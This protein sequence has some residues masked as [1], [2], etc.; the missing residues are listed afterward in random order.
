MPLPQSMQ[1]F[2]DTTPAKKLA[3]PIPTGWYYVQIT[4][5]DLDTPL[6]GGGDE[7]KAYFVFQVAPGQIDRNGDTVRRAKMF[8]H[9]RHGE[10]WGD[11]KTNNIFK[12]LGLPSNAPE[13]EFLGKIVLGYL[14]PDKS[15]EFN[16]LSDVKADDGNYE[17]P[18]G[19]DMSIGG[20]SG[21]QAKGTSNT[22]DD[23]AWE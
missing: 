23:D 6:K 16:D 11:E 12:A 5:C 10:K 9:N 4:E 19:V 14:K 20:S 1:S 13:S 15:K 3:G 22:S 8:W 17:P 21:S 18:A 2:V 7:R